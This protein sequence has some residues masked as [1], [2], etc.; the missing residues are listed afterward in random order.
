MSRKKEEFQ[1]SL[2]RMKE[3]RLKEMEDREIKL[4]LQ[5]DEKKKTLK[6]AALV[7]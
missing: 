4:K 7:K 6:Q 1:R 2:E 3:E 5:N